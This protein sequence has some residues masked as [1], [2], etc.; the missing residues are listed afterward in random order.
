MKWLCYML[1]CPGSTLIRSYM[2]VYTNFKLFRPLFGFF[3]FIQILGQELFACIA[4]DIQRDLPGRE[5]TLGEDLLCI[6]SPWKCREGIEEELICRALRL[7]CAS[8][9]FLQAR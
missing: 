3:D 6:G 8:A 5:L 7:C 4:L 1:S 9:R 2:V